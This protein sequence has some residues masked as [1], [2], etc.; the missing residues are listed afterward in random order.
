MEE[1]RDQ[2]ESLVRASKRLEENTTKVELRQKK[3]GVPTEERLDTVERHEM[4]AMKVSS[5]LRKIE[6]KLTSDK[7]TPNTDANIKYTGIRLPKME[8]KTFDGNVRWHE[9]WESFEHGVHNNA[10]L[11]D[12]QKLQYLKNCLRG[13]AFVTISDL[14]MNGV[15]T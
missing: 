6:K 7:S 13:A 14:D 8:L 5:M 1:L 15:G 2:Q 12:H 9:F 4:Q 11:P 10:S 3:A